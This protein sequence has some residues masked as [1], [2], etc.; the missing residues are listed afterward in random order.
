MIERATR[1]KNSKTQD[2][3]SEGMNLRQ[4]FATSAEN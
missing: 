2:T 1:R 4:V 3:L